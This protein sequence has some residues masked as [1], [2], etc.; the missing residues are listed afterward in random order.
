MLEMVIV[1]PVLLLMLFAL[2]E[3]GLAFGRWITI[4]NAAREGAREAIL[5]RSDCVVAQV[6]ADVRAQV[7]TYTGTLGLSV[8]DSDITVT[9]VCGG[10][11]S[12]SAVTLTVPF[13]FQVLP[14]IAPSLGT[15]LDL[16]GASV[17]RNEG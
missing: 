12:D 16:V 4:N 7:Q 8:P 1:L 17:M 13:N 5:F 2:A 11:G 10:A 6:E 14:G 9:G 3:F 15:S